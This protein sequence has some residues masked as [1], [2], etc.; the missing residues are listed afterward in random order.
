M[1]TNSEAEE[2][3]AGTI[4]PP[5]WCV[6]GVLTML[7]VV[8]SGAEAMRNR[9]FQAK[10][11]WAKV[12]SKEPF[13]FVAFR[14]VVDLSEAPRSATAYVTADTHYSLYINGR[15]VMHGPARSSHGRATV[16][17]LDVRRF[18]KR[19]EN[20]IRVQAFHGNVMYEAQAQAPGFLC[21]IKMTTNGQTQ[22]VATDSTWD[23]R[24]DKTWN[25]SA[26]K[27]SFQRGWVEDIDA[28]LE[29]E[30]DWQP[31]VVIGDAGAAPW[32]II[33]IRDVPLPSTSEV[34]PTSI[35]GAHK[36]TAGEPL[37]EDW[38]GRLR[39]EELTRTDA[40]GIS[41]SGPIELPA[42]T[43]V[44]CD[45]GR[46]YVGFVG[47]D[48]T[49]KAGDVLE[50]VWGERIYDP[51]GAPR[52][53]QGVQCAQTMRYVLRDGKQS[54]LG[55]APQLVRFL[56]I[57]NRGP[58]SVKLRKLRIVRY[59]TSMPDRSEFACSDD[60]LNA[61]YE[62]AR[63]TCRLNT[64]DTFMDCPSRERGGWFHD[65][66]WTAL[67]AYTLFGDTSVNRRMCRQGAES[68]DDPNRIGP[69]GTVAM[70]YPATLTVQP[71]MIPAHELFWVMQVGLDSR[72]TG[73]TGFTQS[74]L[75]AVRRLFRGLAEWRNAE[76]LIDLPQGATWWNFIDWAD[77]KAGPVSV[78]L[79]AVYAK[80]L[81]EAARME[82]LA[83]DPAVADEYE[84]TANRVREALNRHC[85]GG[86]FYPDALEPNESGKLAPSK[87]ACESTQYYV[88]WAGVSDA[89][90]T[91]RMWKALRDDF[92]PT[93]GH[94][95]QPI[96][97]LTRAGLYT[98]FERLQL[99]AQLGDHAA[100][101]RDA[102]AMFLPM[103]QALPGTLWESPWSEIS[104][105]HGLGSTIAAM[106]TEETLGIGV[107]LPV[108]IAPHPGGVKWCKGSVV[109]AK[110]RVR[111]DWK[112]GDKSYEMN[113]SLPR[114]M[115]AEVVL[116]DEARQVFGASSPGW[117]ESFNIRGSRTVLVSP[118]RVEV[119]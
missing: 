57:V 87:E 114:G 45:F 15:Y 79:N 112:L 31:A 17:P 93:P 38:I 8:S 108:R 117:R 51:S 49:G 81:D 70:V 118:G 115:R 50:L 27:F 71:N 65:G 98:F 48:V 19:G 4:I 37:V 32:K 111:V 10:W 39:S 18:L 20:I 68:Q 69:D 42:A 26:P 89:D 30:A 64:L 13:Q 100:F 44:T 67:A 12:E 6:L 105:C 106:L 97:G 72:L 109:T 58:G 119:Q 104:L 84:Q 73:E 43:S 90:R 56:R 53:W 3:R 52:P 28:R 54:F 23:A 116:P 91:A 75:P 61:I 103:A 80:A 59:D 9:Q 113:V 66:Y 88:M 7:A 22:T 77:I 47:F 76:C 1:N 63:W 40:A 46:N 74:M 99:A 110:G 34:S 2:R 55:F 14:K 92:A 21:E 41:A 24:E 95:V 35:V 16:D 36:S 60:G 83:G 82:R 25:R 78:G 33:E 29:S 62:S 11:I 96:Q 94:K 107:G 101:V 102:K 86:L 85:A 5:F